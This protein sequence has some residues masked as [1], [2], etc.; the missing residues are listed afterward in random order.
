MG[1]ALG[2]AAATLLFGL[3][4]LLPQLLLVYACLAVLLAGDWPTV[5]AGWAGFWFLLG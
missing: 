5:E 2:C 4:S 3:R 1:L